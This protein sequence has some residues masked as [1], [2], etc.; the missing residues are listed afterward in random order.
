M[1]ATEEAARIQRAIARYR[2]QEGV[3]VLI[4]IGR[5]DC[6]GRIAIDQLVDRPANGCGRS[7]LVE[8]DLRA[9]DR[10]RAYVAEY[11]RQANELGLCPM[12]GAAI[13]TLLARGGRARRAVS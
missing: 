9:G 1:N 2:V 10:L 3:R 13:S 6:T 4:A 12:S 5:R 7:Y 8:S 11:T